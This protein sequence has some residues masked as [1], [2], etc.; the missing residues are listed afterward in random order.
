MD[1]EAAC[2]GPSSLC[3]SWNLLQKHARTWTMS[4]ADIDLRGTFVVN[5]GP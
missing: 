2:H 3:M 1:R 5:A 4:R